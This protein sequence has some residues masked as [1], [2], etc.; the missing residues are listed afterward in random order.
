MATLLTNLAIAVVGQLLMEVFMP[1][2]KAQEGPR[3]ADLNVPSVTP[4]Q[5]I[6]K[7]WGIIRCGCMVIWTTG[8]TEHKNVKK[9]K[10]SKTKKQKQI[11]YTYTTNIACAF[12]DGPVSRVRR[13]F[14]NSKLLWAASDLDVNWDDLAVE[15][16]AYKTGRET[17]WSDYYATE[18]D[19]ARFGYSTVADWIATDRYAGLVAGA[20]AS[21]MAEW[22]DTYGWADTNN[23]G[24]N[25]NDTQNIK[26]RYTSIEFFLGT[27]TQM[28]S[29]LIEEFEGAGNVPPFRGVSY[30]TIRRLQL[31]D[32]GNTIP[33]FTVEVEERSGGVAIR[34]VLTDLSLRAGL[35]SD[36]LLFED[37]D[38]LTVNGYAL[39]DMSSVRAAAEHLQAVFPFDMSEY[40]DQ[41]RF[42]LRDRAAVGMILSDDLRA[43]TSDSSDIP[44]KIE[45]TRVDDLQLPKR[46]DLAFQDPNRNCSA[47]K[48]SARRVFSHSNQVI[49]V[50]LTISST[51]TIMKKAAETLLANAVASRNSFKIN[52]PPKYL[53]FEVGD[54][55]LLPMGHDTDYRKVRITEYDIGA[56]FLL[57]LKV[58]DHIETVSNIEAI[59]DV[60]DVAPPR[61]DTTASTVW[62][63]YDGP[64]ISGDE[65]ADSSMMVVMGQTQGMWLGGALYRDMNS[66]SVTTVF[67]ETVSATPDPLWEVDVTSDVPASQGVVLSPLL[68][69]MVPDAIDYHSNLVIRFPLDEDYFITQSLASAAA[70]TDNIFLIGG[71]IIQ[72]LTVTPLGSNTYAFTKILRGLRGTDYAMHGHVSGERAFAV[73]EDTFQFWT[74]PQTLIGGTI[75]YRV[76][77]TDADIT[78]GATEQVVFTGG[79]RRPLPPAVRAALRNDDGDL[80]IILQPR[81]RFNGNWLN[82]V[83]TSATEG[84]TVFRVEVFTIPAYSDTTV[85]LATYDITSVDWVYSAAA[86]AADHGAVPSKVHL[87][88]TQ[89]SG[90]TIDGFPRY[91]TV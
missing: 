50:D 84:D 19:A 65:V 10:V 86:Q 42:R 76:V 41:I 2:P 49:S 47:N 22:D 75:D 83:T 63:I 34:D 59:A 77:T 55:L 48:V 70:G 68:A 81:A 43:H 44:A 89:I 73:S 1:N 12:N 8:L 36:Q 82:G 62:A 61:E 25:D 35:T 17:Y 90:G 18:D 58:V 88:I 20:V 3:L 37:M 57:E 7:N 40:G 52:V 64:S 27:E 71:E 72:A 28:P 31:E 5:P 85:L 91:E 51:T 26:E 4:G 56:N 23:D 74:L 14:A 24:K 9:V 66:G 16:A 54:V 78:T 87:S 6:G 21:D 39:T 60:S 45:R 67:G 29:S 46:V 33:T 69:G 15:R 53:R 13:I 30:F 38:D 11:T 80:T 79:Y 32:F